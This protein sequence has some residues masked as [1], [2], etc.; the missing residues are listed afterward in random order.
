VAGVWGAG[1]AW[2]RFCEAVGRPDLVDHPD[3]AENVD[4]VA[5]REELNAILRPIFER[6]TTAE[7]RVRFQAAKGLFGPILSIPEAVEQDQAAATG[8]ITTMEHETLG[9][10]PTVSPVVGLSETPGEIAGPPPLLGQHTVEILAELGYAP[11]EM[12]R[13]VDHGIALV[14]EADPVA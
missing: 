8:A 10:I 5:H 1:E 3:F 12:Q 6:R 4:R 9:T 7:W 2:P 14:T 11:D 13:M